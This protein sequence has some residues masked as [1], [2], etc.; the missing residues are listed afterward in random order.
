M[1]FGQYAG[2]S[3]SGVKVKIGT[4]RFRIV[5][6]DVKRNGKGEIVRDQQSNKAKFQLDAVIIAGPYEGEQMTRTMP[7][8][9]G[10]N[11]E[12]HTYAVFA[13]FLSIITGIPCGDKRLEEGVEPEDLKGREFE[14][15]AGWEGK[16][17]NIIKFV[18]EVEEEPQARPPQRQPEPVRSAAPGD[19]TQQDLAHRGRGAQPPADVFER[20][21]LPQRRQIDALAKLKHVNEARLRLLVASIAGP[22]AS[23]DPDLAPQL[24]ELLKKEIAA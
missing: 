22:N 11:S 18:D 20:L 5:K 17:N 13:Q 9:F 12:S 8:A 21:S 1:G 7:I 23:L 10:E 14:A 19:T 6:A 2:G 4:Y 24:V 15:V 16:Y 3:A